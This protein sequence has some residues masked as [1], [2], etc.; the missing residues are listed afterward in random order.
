[1]FSNVFHLVS[2]YLSK[3]EA[4]ARPLWYK[5][6]SRWLGHTLW[7]VL[8]LFSNSVHWKR[9]RWHL[10]E[11]VPDPSSPTCGHKSHFCT[12][13]HTHLPGPHCNCAWA[14]GCTAAGKRHHSKTD[15]TA[16]ATPT[17][18]FPCAIFI[19]LSGIL[20]TYLQCLIKCLPP[21]RSPMCVSCTSGFC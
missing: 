9:D 11:V 8:V 21:S 12:P 6:T 13:L 5:L 15:A 20:I 14:E 18:Q 4:L 16:T 10:I 3:M 7:A 2:E 17:V 19:T 1:M